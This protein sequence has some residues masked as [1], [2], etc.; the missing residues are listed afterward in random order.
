MFVKTYQ[1]QC[2]S[3]GRTPDTWTRRG[4]A[5][6]GNRALVQTVCPQGSDGYPNNGRQHMSKST[7]RVC[8]KGLLK[9]V[10]STL[11]LFLCPSQPGN[12]PGRRK[13]EQHEVIAEACYNNNK[14]SNRML[15]WSRTL[16]GKSDL[17][18]QEKLNLADMTSVAG[19]GS[20]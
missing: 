1:R 2:S 8:R 15:F 19:A 12:P 4:P 10:V 5:G 9:T 14:N 6:Q 11:R 20:F 17:T 7:P 3:R 18:T 16:V 13:D